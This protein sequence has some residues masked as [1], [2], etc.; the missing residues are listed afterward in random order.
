MMRDA[1]E[2]G[3]PLSIL[4][5]MRERDGAAALRAVCAS[6][7]WARMELF[8]G[9][10]APALQAARMRAAPDAVLLEID[11]RD[12]AATRHDMALLAEAFS[13]TPVI[14]TCAGVGIELAR[15][16]MRLGAFDVVPQPVE[17][18]ELVAAF[19]GL[20]RR[21]KTAAG[22][23]ASAGW[24]VAFLKS[25]G[26]CGTSTLALQTGAILAARH[27]QAEAEVCLL[28]LDLQFGT[29]ALGLDLDD[30]TGLGEL[31]EVRDRLD[32]TLL[33]SLMG[34]H[35]SGLDV[36]AVPRSLMPLDVLSS[37]SVADVLT[38][39]REEYQTVFLDLPLAWTAWSHAALRL[40]D[41]IVLVVQPDVAG[42]RRT[43]RQLDALGEHGLGG[44]PLRLVLNQR[45]RARGAAA[46]RRE[47]ERALGRRIDF[48][49]AHDP[50]AF[51]EALNRGLP[52][53]RTARWSRAYRN[54][55]R[56][57]DG[58]ALALANRPA[59]LSRAGPVTRPVALGEAS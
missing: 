24:V 52:L 13:E 25:S 31:I 50:R 14:A 47:A 22:R 57:A 39:A 46:R 11:P 51:G 55:R 45:D 9:L 5:I 6:I 56:L 29:A 4:A 48:A 41:L 34:H 38:L 8:H 21:G 44:V 54:L 20:R 53:V 17:R 23:A 42:V 7:P 59:A 32:G 16:L 28:D 1:S 12:L 15:N 37:E 43:R 35:D 18:A 2:S 27:A 40:C 33:R 26:G 3:P 30:R 19:A 36:L 10:V 49:I 58:I